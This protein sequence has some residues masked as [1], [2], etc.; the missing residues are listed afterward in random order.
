M[1]CIIYNVAQRTINLFKQGNDLS[2]SLELRM[3]VLV[4]RVSEMNVARHNFD[5]VP[6]PVAKKNVA[7]SYCPF[8]VL[9]SKSA[10]KRYALHLI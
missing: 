6:A 3:S 4:R 7:N 1:L 10:V 5:R 9:G 8:S 2:P